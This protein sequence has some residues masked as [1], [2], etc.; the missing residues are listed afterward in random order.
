[1]NS[2]SLGVMTGIP[3]GRGAAEPRARNVRS[4]RQRYPPAGGC[5][6]VVLTG[7]PQP[8]GPSPCSK[9]QSR[10]SSDHWFCHVD[11]M[12]CPTSWITR[13][14]SGPYAAL[15]SRASKFSTPPTSETWPTFWVAHAL[16]RHTV[17]PDD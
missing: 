8:R 9:P 12:S 3:R 17:P 4:C 11:H 13:F 15:G 7:D 14:T 1:M 16:E 2:E 5:Q 6:I 10:G